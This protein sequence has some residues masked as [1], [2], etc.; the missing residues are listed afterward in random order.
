M[1]TLLAGRG[2]D[3]DAQDY[4][5]GRS[6]LHHAVE[7]NQLSVTSALLFRLGASVDAP[8]FDKSTPLHLA[9]GHGLCDMVAVLIA[10]GADARL[11]NAE[12]DLPI[13]L[14]REEQV[15]VYPDYFL[16]KRMLYAQLHAC[17]KLLSPPLKRLGEV[18]F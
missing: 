4:G 6:A 1:M 9:A 10:A 3:V 5:S 7:S 15:S 18:F 8:T 11:K 2:V 16:A 12:D 14:A 17:V 13:D